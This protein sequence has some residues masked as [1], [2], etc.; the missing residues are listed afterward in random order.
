M[1][2]LF[3]LIAA[4]TLLLATIV[5]LGCVGAIVGIWI[6]QHKV[7]EKVESVFAQLDP[8]LQRASEAIQGVSRSLTTVSAD[9]ALAR[10]GPREPDD[11][12]AREAWRRQVVGYF[13][14]LIGRLRV[15]VQAENT[16]SS[17]LRGVQDLPLSEAVHINPDKLDRAAEQAKQLSATLE[18]LPARFGSKDREVTE[19]EVVAVA[20]DLARALQR[21]QETVADW[22]AD[23]DAGRAE[24]PQ[25]KARVLRWLTL[26][27][28]AGTGVCVWVG[29]SQLSLFAHA[30]RWPRWGTESSTGSG[31]HGE[32]PG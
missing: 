5:F 6:F 19:T 13:Q 28:L 26:T 25:F 12:Y 20:N 21:C 17:L 27:A 2:A 30:W 24:L 11:L 15:F 3:R 14:T 23:L 16:V 10:K 29:L 32:V 22:Q 18:E 31:C 7:S 8:G 1:R 4:V 9:V